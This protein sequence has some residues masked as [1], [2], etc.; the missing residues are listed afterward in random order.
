MVYNYLYS[1]YAK[2]GEFEKAKI[3]IEKALVLDPLSLRINTS[4][5]DSL[6]YLERYDDAIAQYEKTLT[7]DEN[8]R[9]AIG[10]LA[11]VHVAKENYN[12]AEVLFNRRKNLIN[13]PLKGLMGLGF[14]YAKT[15][16]IKE[17]NDCLDQIIK[18]SN[19]ET[20]V[21]LEIDLAILYTG[22]GDFDKALNHLEKAIN[23][24]YGI[25]YLK[26]HYGFKELRNKER[27]INLLHKV[28]LKD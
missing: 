14:V 4:V 21:L 17:A 12:A 18:R 25:I 2:T 22:F 23:E 5:G 20:N 11:W 24:K 6:F 3:E 15:G 27:F 9:S 26:T 7:L 13:K 1:Y 19:K 10:N 8:F 16:R 28:G